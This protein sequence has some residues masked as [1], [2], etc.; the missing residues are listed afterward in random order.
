LKKLFE[1]IQEQIGT[2]LLK[3]DGLEREIK[4]LYPEFKQANTS[5]I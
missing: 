2:F 3:I 1:G 4:E 5:Q